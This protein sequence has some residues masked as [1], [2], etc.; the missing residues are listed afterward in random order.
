MGSGEQKETQMQGHMQMQMQV[1]PQLPMQLQLQKHTPP[2]G[3]SLVGAL[4]R[5]ITIDDALHMEPDDLGLAMYYSSHCVDGSKIWPADA[6]RQQGNGCLYAAV[7]VLGN[8]ALVQQWTLPNDL[9]AMSRS[10]VSAIRL[11]NQALASPKECLADSTLLATLILGALEIKAAPSRSTDSWKIHIKGA[12]ALLSLRG[13]S[14]VTSRL[15]S[16][17]YFQVSTYATST[18]IMASERVPES[19]KKLREAAKAYLLDGNHPSWKYQGATFRFTDLM[20]DLAASASDRDPH[21]MSLLIDRAHSVYQDLKAIFT[22]ADSGWQYTVVPSDRFLPVVNYEHVYPTILSSQI[23]NGSRAAIVSVCSA[24]AHLGTL[25]PRNF[26]LSPASRAFVDSC[27]HII[28]MTSVEILAAVPRASTLNRSQKPSD[29]IPDSKS[30]PINPMSG[31]SHAT[32]VNEHALAEHAL[33]EHAPVFREDRPDSQA[34]PYMNGCQMQWSVYFAARCRFVARPARVYLVE[35]LD[36][37][38]RTMEIAQWKTTARQLR[39]EL[40]LD[41]NCRPETP[42]A[43]PVRWTSVATA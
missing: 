19:V 10:Y 7:K 6:L 21:R 17:L 3:P 41:A 42:L 5:Y 31:R 8:V 22:G 4:I 24:A 18:C 26:P 38:A 43:Q 27:V 36:N 14:Q 20:A 9:Q 39:A 25:L 13:P 23:W 32:I 33:A 40:D 35:I 28:N 12:A 2:S 29:S 16:A 11:L 1:Q 30:N 37:A 34:V 15:G